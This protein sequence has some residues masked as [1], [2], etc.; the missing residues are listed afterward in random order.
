MKQVVIVEHR[1]YSLS[2]KETTDNLPPD[3]F[4]RRWQYVSVSEE[5]LEEIK[6]KKGKEV[7]A[8]LQ[9]LYK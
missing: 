5:K 4:M 2:I 3:Y 8:I 9:S 1:D 7:Q 6:S